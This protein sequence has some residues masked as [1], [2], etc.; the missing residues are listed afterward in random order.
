MRRDFS[1]SFDL[2]LAE[3]S[4]NSDQLISLLT[5]KAIGLGSFVRLR[6]VLSLEC[7]FGPRLRL[8]GA[9]TCLRKWR[10]GT[11][12]GEGLFGTTGA[13]THLQTSTVTATECT[14]VHTY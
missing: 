14:Y 11:P 6:I 2:P 5:S 7:C 13:Y 9:L 4:P 10:G 3:K 8:A 12:S 1:F